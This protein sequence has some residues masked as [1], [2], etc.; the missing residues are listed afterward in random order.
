MFVVQFSRHYLEGDSRQGVFMGDLA[1]TLAGVILLVLSGNLFHLCL[2]WVTTSVVLHRLLLFYCH[3]PGAVIA[4]RKKFLVARFG[5][6]CLIGACLLIAKTF[7]TADIAS[8][9]TQARAL[10]PETL[11]HALL[12][13]TFLI[14]A[15]CLL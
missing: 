12:W 1:L 7:Q 11:P 15:K 10:S 13:A 14:A 9:L 2:A 6:A 8:I 4:A 3:R 5:D